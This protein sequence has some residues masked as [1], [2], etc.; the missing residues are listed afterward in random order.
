MNL[1]ELKEKYA[2]LQTQIDSIKA[3]GE[4]RDGGLTKDDYDA[5]SALMDQQDEIKGMIDTAERLETREPVATDNGSVDV[6]DIRVVGPAAEADEYKI[7]EYLAEIAQSSHNIKAGGRPL[8]R[9][10]NYQKRITA[11]ATGAGEVIP[12][13]GGYLVGEDFTSGIMK[14]AYENNQVLSRCTRRTI[15][16]N[17]NKVTING[18]DETSRA[19]GSRHGGIRSYWLNEGAAMTASKP[20][21]RK[22]NLELNKHG[23]LFYAGD[24]LLADTTLL[25]QE[26]ED[27]VADEIAFVGQEAVINGTGAGQPLGIL[28]AGCLVSQGKETGQGAATIVYENV[29]KMLTRKWGELSRYVWLYNQEILP[30]LAQMNVAVGTGGAP[31]YLPNAGIAEAP[32]QILAGRPLIEIEQAAALGTVGDLMLVDLSQYVVAEKGGVQAAMSIHVEFTS[33]ETVFRWLT[34]LDGQ[35][36]WSSALTPYKGSATRSPFVALAT[37]S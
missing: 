16:G 4:A 25:G 34:R 36:M 27:A 24:E 9:V 14:R 31:V 21:F 33:D 29:L 7:G 35:P 3:E 1:K 6:T 37:R 28:N 26:V 17:A 22:I 2:G 10:E 30:Q 13:D 5:M 12:S 11:A 32:F 19:T 18:I 8:P 23:I 15:S 20:K